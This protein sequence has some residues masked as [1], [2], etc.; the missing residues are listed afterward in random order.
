MRRRA[1]AADADRLSVVGG[2]QRAP[3]AH[4][5]AGDVGLV[6][7]GDAQRAPRARRWEK[8]PVNV[9]VNFVPLALALGGLGLAAFLW[10]LKNGQFDDLDGAAWRAI[11]DN[12]LPENKR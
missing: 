7:P 12:D 1:E 6:N 5:G 10:A 8:R 4:R 2:L 3:A 9:L 11:S